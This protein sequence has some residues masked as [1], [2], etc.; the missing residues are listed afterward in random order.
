MHPLVVFQ[1]NHPESLKVLE[2]LLSEWPDNVSEQMSSI[3]TNCSKQ[4]KNDSFERGTQYLTRLITQSGYRNVDTAE[5]SDSL[6][7]HQ[8]I[9]K[10]YYSADKVKECHFSLTK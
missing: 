1:A 8:L 7:L 5:Q 10:V 3:F 6:K 4:N 9:F 2:D